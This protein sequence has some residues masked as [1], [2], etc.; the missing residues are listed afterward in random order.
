MAIVAFDYVAWSAR[1]PEL[2]A[3]VAQPL[4]QAYFNEAQLYCDNTVA[5]PII[6]DT[7]G[8]VRSMLLNMVT[9][10]I[11]S[12][13]API[14]GQAASPLVGRISSATEGSVTVAIENQYPPGTVQWWQSTK[15]G[16]AFWAATQQYR[17]MAYFP[18]TPRN[19]D[20]YA[21][22]IRGF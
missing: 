13:N 9:A 8:G 4:A 6:D 16:A 11:A 12:L 19:M 21:P 15:Y 7:V 22:F 14:G 10:H 5:S 2:S 3:S 17:K 1:Y 20:P 18:G